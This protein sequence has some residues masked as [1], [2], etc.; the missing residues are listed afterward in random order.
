MDRLACKENRQTSFKLNAPVGLAL[1]CFLFNAHSITKKLDVLHSYLASLKFELFFISESWAGNKIS[2]SQIVHNY[3]YS[4]I[5]C[6]RDSS[7]KGGG[8]LILIS[9]MINF[10]INT[11]PKLFEMDFLSV[12]IIDPQNSKTIRN[13]THLQTT[14]LQK[15]RKIFAVFRL[16]I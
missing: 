12:E 8:V 7:K 4:V 13:H 3:P 11:T 9:N 1:N 15:T 10:S 14:K 16:F 2:D 6:D 5:R